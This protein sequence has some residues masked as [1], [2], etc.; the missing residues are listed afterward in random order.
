[1]CLT[2]GRAPRHAA[3]DV[4]TLNDSCYRQH[5]DDDFPLLG[6]PP[7]IELINTVYGDGDA[8]VDYLHPDDRA[9]RWSSAALGPAAAPVDPAAL[10]ELRDA[11][12]RLVIAAHAERPLDPASVELVNRHAAAASGYLQ[13]IAAPS[14]HAIAR[15]R[16]G[17]LARL[18][19]SGIGVLCGPDPIRRCEGEGCSLFF[20]QTHGRRR[21][22]HDG[23]SHRAR[24]Q[25]YS[26]R[27]R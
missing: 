27:H 18:A 5:M 14:I 7:A 13:L 23:C 20:V 22:C 3:L 15:D 8:A 10:R 1:M 6:E 17:P 26:R 25:R 4:L 9:E 2:G 16:A 19:T 21:F 24:Q 12:R 11:L